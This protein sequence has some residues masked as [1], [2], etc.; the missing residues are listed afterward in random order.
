MILT[1][2]RVPTGINGLDFMLGG[3][4]PLNSIVLIC[5]GLGAGKTV[6]SLQ[7]IASALRRGEPCVYI[8]FEEPVAKQY[9]YAE[10]FG[11]DLNSADERGLLVSLSFK[12][13]PNS[14][15]VFNQSFA[16][17]NYSIEQSMVE[18]VQK[19][20]A[21]HV[22]V[23]SLTSILVQESKSDGIRQAVNQLYE[24]IRL[25]GCNALIL[26]EGVPNRGVFYMEQFLSDGLILMNRE[27]QDFQ[28]IKTVLIDKMRGIAF[29]DQPRRYSI[30]DK[31]IKVYNSEPVIM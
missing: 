16:D 25:L 30:S 31:G 5:G 7:Y 9:G 6:F 20:G 28:L 23:D 18:A 22:V 17:Q 24:A 13:C 11:W 27:V 29:D 19:T 26:S 2:Q 12:I 14:H 8:C 1:D 3:G 10:A 15:T 4:F 21:K